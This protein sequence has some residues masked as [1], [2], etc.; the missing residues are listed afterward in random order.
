MTLNDFYLGHFVM[1]ERTANLN[2]ERSGDKF[3]DMPVNVTK[4]AGKKLGLNVPQVALWQL[5]EP[6]RTYQ[7]EHSPQFYGMFPSQ[8]C[9][10][11]NFHR[12]RNMMVSSAVGI[13]SIMAVRPFDLFSQNPAM[14]MTSFS[15]RCSV[16][17]AGTVIVV[18][19]KKNS[20]N[21]FEATNLHNYIRII[22]KGSSIDIA[23]PNLG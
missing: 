16:L 8:M 12:I 17:L 6:V 5:V 14:D 23:N 15:L 11:V 13:L 22:T 21:A 2:P 10:R 20:R 4:S 18:R 1:E 3:W 19:V 7:K 9:E